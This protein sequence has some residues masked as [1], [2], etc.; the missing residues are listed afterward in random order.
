[1]SESAAVMPIEGILYVHCRCMGCGAALLF[2]ADAPL[3]ERCPG[4]G[5]ALPEPHRRQVAACQT[6]MRRPQ[7]D[8]GG[9]QADPGLRFVGG[10]ESVAA[11]DAQLASNGL[12]VYTI[13][14]K[15]HIAN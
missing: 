11:F 8:R 10:A 6:V 4:C 15:P 1:M 7:S 2:T 12:A 14:L 13:T 3:I 9:S 5:A